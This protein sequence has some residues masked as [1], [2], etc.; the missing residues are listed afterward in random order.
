MIT[1]VQLSDMGTYTCTASSSRGGGGINA[2][3]EVRLEVRAHVEQCGI[4]GHRHGNDDEAERDKRIVRG[5]A[6][7]GVDEWPWQVNKLNS[8]MHYIRCMCIVILNKLL[9][10]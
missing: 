8:F 3:T 1:T 10:Q 4:K 5:Y 6:V 7:S 2:T 9:V